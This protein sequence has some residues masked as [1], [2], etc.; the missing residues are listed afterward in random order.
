MSEKSNESELLKLALELTDSWQ[1][2]GLWNDAQTLLNGLFPVTK[3]LGP[4]ASGRIWLNLGKVLTDQSIFGAKETLS[5]RSEAFDKALELAKKADDSSLIGDVYDATGFSIHVAYLGSD[6]SKEPGN[7]LEL[8]ER[9]LDLRTQAGTAGQIA[10]STFHI[11]LVYD[12]IRKD[13]ETAL[14]YHNKAYQLASEADAKV[15]ASY[16]IRHIGFARL[17]AQ[18]L[19]GAKNAL[20]ESLV[21]RDA[22]GFHPGSAYALATLAHVENLLGNKDQA[23]L[24]LERSHK[25]FEALEATSHA[26]SIKEQISSLDAD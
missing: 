13:Y 10:E 1:L 8:F 21:L 4:A 23:R 11:G 19:D 14:T 2:Q 6:R 9:G 17:A 22:A 25:I 7:E 3:K 12:V 18:D 24:H 26:N 5:E 15:I 16:A 20:T